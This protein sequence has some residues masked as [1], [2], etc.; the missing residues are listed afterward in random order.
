[1]LLISIII[2]S[3]HSIMMV[4]L[5]QS[6]ARLGSADGQ[7]NR[8]AGITIDPDNNLVYAQ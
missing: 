1:M 8:P 6:G 2:V 3:K 5:S 7:F 4:T